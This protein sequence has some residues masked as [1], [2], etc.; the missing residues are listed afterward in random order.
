METT[1]NKKSFSNVPFLR[2]G[3]RSDKFLLFV[4]NFSGIYSSYHTITRTKSE[5]SGRLIYKLSMKK[6]IYLTHCQLLAIFLFISKPE[7]LFD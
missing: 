7:V 5:T 3:L 6:K 4:A 2:N 1:E